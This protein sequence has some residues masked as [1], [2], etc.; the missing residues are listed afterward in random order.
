MMTIGADAAAKKTAKECTQVVPQLPPIT[1]VSV[2]EVI[3]SMRISNKSIDCEC[4]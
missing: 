3:Y 1:Y 4:E 2:I